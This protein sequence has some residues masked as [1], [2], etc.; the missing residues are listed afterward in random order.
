MEKGEHTVKTANNSFVDPEGSGTI[1]F[2][3]DTP[4]ANPVKIVLQHVLYVPACGTH[5]LLSILQV[6]RKG[7]NFDFKL[8]GSTAIL[9]S[10]LIYEAPLINS[11]FVLKATAAAV[12]KASVVIDNPQSATPSCTPEISK[13]YSNIRPAVDDKD[14]LVWYA[15]L[16][17]LSL[18]AIKRLPNTV[19]GIQLH[20]KSPST[21]TC[22]ACIM[23]KMFQKAVQHLCSEDK[24]KTRLL[25]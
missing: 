23:G 10:V 21:C 18:P 9:G 3:V 8:D 15:R 2:Y 16:G 13:V 5:H 1:T 19:R 20:A 4:N 17:H 22:D 11:L 6:M 25:E 7:V 24:A 12:L 14:I